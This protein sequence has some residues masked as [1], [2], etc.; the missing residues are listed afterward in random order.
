MLEDRMIKEKSKY[1]A[2]ANSADGSDH[3]IQNEKNE[4][5][6]L[7]MPIANPGDPNAPSKEVSSSKQKWSNIFTIWCA[8]FA[9][10]SDGYQSKFS[11]SSFSGLYDTDYLKYNLMSLTNGK[12][13]L[14]L[15]I[16]LHKELVYS[17][18]TVFID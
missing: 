17:C 11:L 6:Q 1:L 14:F 13:S 2:A 3:D 18:A 8:G 9:L 10:I 12:N 16:T 4:I 7:K 5:Q 15:F